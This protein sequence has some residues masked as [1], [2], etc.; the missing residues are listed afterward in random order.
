MIIYKPVGQE[1]K[2]KKHLKEENALYK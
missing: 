1:A 2:K